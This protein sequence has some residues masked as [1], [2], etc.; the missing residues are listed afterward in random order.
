MWSFGVTLSELFTLGSRP[1]GKWTNAKILTEVF[2]HG[3]RLPMPPRCPGSIY[4]VMVR[5]NEGI[6]Y[7]SENDN[8]FMSNNNKLMIIVVL[9]NCKIIIAAPSFFF[10]WNF[11]QV[12]LLSFVAFTSNWF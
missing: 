8:K 11:I 10:F 7:C 12:V 5:S 2:E 1:Y 3:Y 6:D 4:G 9:N